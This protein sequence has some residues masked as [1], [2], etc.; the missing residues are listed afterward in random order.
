M[1]KYGGRALES[2]AFNG[3]F[4]LLKLLLEKGA[5][6][7]YKPH[8]GYIGA[9]GPVIAEFAGVSNVKSSIKIQAVKILLAY[10]ANINA[11]KAGGVTPLMSAVKLRDIKFIKFLLKNGADINKKDGWGATALDYVICSP[12]MKKRQ[13]II[14]I[15]EAAGAKRGSGKPVQIAT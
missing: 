10:G 15:L 11:G 8:G 14:R 7:N 1:K 4:K 3:R 2:A 13:E 12:N 5:D 9:P 6:A